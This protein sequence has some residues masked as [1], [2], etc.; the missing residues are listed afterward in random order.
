MTPHPR[1]SKKYLRAQ[2]TIEIRVEAAIISTNSNEGQARDPL[3]WAN[4]VLPP[5]YDPVATPRRG[6]P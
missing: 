5:V 1:L 3:W 6:H 4:A 2:G